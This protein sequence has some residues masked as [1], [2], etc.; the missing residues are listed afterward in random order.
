MIQDWNEDKYC[1]TSGATGSVEQNKARFI[2]DI[3]NSTFEHLE[4]DYYLT[5][6]TATVHEKKINIKTYS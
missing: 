6:N 1:T 2:I 3:Y 5:D 4:F